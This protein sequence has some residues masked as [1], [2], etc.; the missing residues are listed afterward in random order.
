MSHYDFYFFGM[1][2]N[3]DK[4]I[5]KTTQTFFN[6]SARIVS[7]LISFRVRISHS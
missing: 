7:L 5:I 4:I 2:L 6:T 3:F 1:D